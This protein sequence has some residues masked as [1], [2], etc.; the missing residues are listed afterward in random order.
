MTNDERARQ[1][2][3][4]KNDSGRVYDLGQTEARRISS[5][6]DEPLHTL[7]HGMGIIWVNKLEPPRW[8]TVWELAQAMGYTVDPELAKHTGTENLFTRGHVGP[9]NRTRHSMVCQIG[10]AMHVNACGGV[11]FVLALLHPKAVNNFAMPARDDEDTS[12]PPRCLA[13]RRPPP[14]LSTRKAD[15][16]ERQLM[17]SLRMRNM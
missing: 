17:R 4:L 8:F 1:I 16:E 2:A 11:F 9:H 15:P 7:M 12:T 10:N 5:A 13:A 3:Y 6:Y 14:V